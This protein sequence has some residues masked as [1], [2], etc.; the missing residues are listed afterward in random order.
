MEGL[1]SNVFVIG[2]E[3]TGF[4]MI[5]VLSGVI[6]DVEPWSKAVTIVVFNWSL[7]LDVWD[8][9]IDK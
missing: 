5:L 9:L 2:V 3:D 7:F 6:L 4:R 8:S 1:V